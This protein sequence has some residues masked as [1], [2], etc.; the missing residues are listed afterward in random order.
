M[1]CFVFLSLRLRWVYELCPGRYVRQF[2]ETT[3]MD[4]ISGVAST[5]VDTEHILG[6]YAKE[7]HETHPNDEEW[8]HVVNSTI[9]G[10]L[11]SSLLYPDASTGGGKGGNGAYYYQEYTNGDVCDHEDVTESSIKAGAVGGGHVYRAC[12]VQYSCGN[13][14]EMNV[15]E[16]HTCHYIVEVTVPSLCGHPLFKP[17]ISKKQ[18]LKCLPAEDSLGRQKYIW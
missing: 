14:L 12:T 8:K 13:R 18:V 5:A 11:F 16:D 4:R 7:D 10:D 6:N 2:H 3:M 17:P 15:K 9:G 1:G